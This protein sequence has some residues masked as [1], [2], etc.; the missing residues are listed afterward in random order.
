MWTPA[1]LPKTKKRRVADLA[2]FFMFLGVFFLLGACSTWIK[3]VEYGS[4]V[5]Y[6]DHFEYTED[7]DRE[8]MSEF[9]REAEL[10][11]LEYERQLNAKMQLGWTK[12]RQDLVDEK[13]IAQNGEIVDRDSAEISDEAREYA[14]QQENTI[15]EFLGDEKL[16]QR[17]PAQFAD[18]KEWN[19]EY[20]DFKDEEVEQA[21]LAPEEEVVRYDSMAGDI[22][23]LNAPVIGEFD[24]SNNTSQRAVARIPQSIKEED[25]L[26]LNEPILDGQRQKI[27]RSGFPEENTSNKE[28]LGGKINVSDENAI[29]ARGVAFTGNELKTKPFKK[30]D[31]LLNAYYYAKKTDRNWFDVSQRIY[32]DIKSADKLKKW[33]NNLSLVAGS[34]VYY[35][36][37]NRAEDEAKM[38]NY[39][40]DQKLGLAKYTVKKGDSLASI[41]EKLYGS[42]EL[43]NEL[44]DLNKIS[45]PTQLEVGENLVF[46]AK[47][48][49]AAPIVQSVQK[50]AEQ[51][52]KAEVVTL[53]KQEDAEM[54]VNQADQNEQ[55]TNAPDSSQ[56]QIN[57]SQNQGGAT[58]LMSAIQ[59]IGD[60]S[61]SLEEKRNVLF[62]RAT[63][64]S[65]EIQA[66][67]DGI[68]E[69]E[70]G[71]ALADADKNAEDKD[72]AEKRSKLNESEGADR[73]I[74]SE[75]KEEI[76]VEEAL[77]PEGTP[78]E[79]TSQ[80][81]G[82]IFA[83]ITV[84]QKQIEIEQQEIDKELE[85]QR[86][87]KIKQNEK[88]S[89]KSAA[90]TKN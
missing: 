87:E 59:S 81:F 56:K 61:M 71:M 17:A 51:A 32:G 4:K 18:H 84:I 67:E 12:T 52:P 58:D 46:A 88:L 80:N 27:A 49:K 3:S 50:E 29:E 77:L 60:D 83:D 66:F 43:W 34:I 39:V 5:N 16:I 64:L 40:F 53:N 11:A 8:M 36:S 30:G 19:K 33:N 44:Q 47:K 31:D 57:V 74:A 86:L 26:E 82:Q 6:F 20:P 7:V 72:M 54:E 35:Q 23:E 69:A 10:S 13:I 73:K 2:P 9:G 89:D 63:E 1:G 68:A 55:K 25:V 79:L 38:L 90:K 76:V 85:R 14:R 45:D 24:Y 48:N 22:L 28:H 78:E 42:K 15:D 62:S 65:E 41:A 75:K 70:E 21:E 37:A